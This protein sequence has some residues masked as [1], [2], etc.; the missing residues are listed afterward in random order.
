MQSL[1]KPGAIKFLSFD[2][3]FNSYKNDEN[4]AC[5]TCSVV[6]TEWACPMTTCS[7]FQEEKTGL[8]TP[9]SGL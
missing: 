1:D 8:A 2:S 5:Y 4:Q 7:V 9:I 3:P 6:L